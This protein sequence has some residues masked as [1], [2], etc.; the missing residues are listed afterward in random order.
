MDV[1][2]LR[3]ELGIIIKNIS[4]QLSVIKG[5][6]KSRYIAPDYGGSDTG[7][8]SESDM[9]MTVFESL[10]SAKFDGDAVS[11]VSTRNTLKEIKNDL[12]DRLDVFKEL[13]QRTKDLEKQVR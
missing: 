6:R 7:S 1:N 3:E 2:L 11:N 9:S 10:F 5:L 4:S 13:M 8:D 12:Q